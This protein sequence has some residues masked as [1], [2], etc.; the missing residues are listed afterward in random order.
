MEALVEEG[1]GSRHVEGGLTGVGEVEGAGSPP[2]EAGAGAGVGMKK[3]KGRRR[4]EGERDDMWGP[5]V[6]EWRERI[7]T[8][9]FWS[10]R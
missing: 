8:R 7:T 2:H 6:S 9:A 4:M 3:S 10:I 1:G 5:D